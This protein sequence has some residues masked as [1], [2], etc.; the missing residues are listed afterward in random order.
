[1]LECQS[2][3]TNGFV[4]LKLKRELSIPPSIPDHL[5]GKNLP[6]PILWQGKNSKSKISPPQAADNVEYNK[7]SEDVA[8][9]LQSVQEKLTKL[10]EKRAARLDNAEVTKSSENVTT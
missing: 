1:M 9:E 8:T 2:G 4:Q 3:Q 7:S 6:M 10:K 5:Q